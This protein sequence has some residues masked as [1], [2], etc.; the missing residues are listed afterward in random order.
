MKKLDKLNIFACAALTA[1][2]CMSNA[3]FAEG[4]IE[5]VFPDETAAPLTAGEPARNDTAPPV[6][7][8]AVSPPYDPNTDSLPEPNVSAQG[9]GLFEGLPKGRG[10]V[11]NLCEYWETNGYPDYVSYAAEFG[12]A[13][14]D[15]ATQ[16][17]TV[18]RS[19]TIGAVNITEEQKQEIL[20]LVSSDYSVS[21]EAARY[22][23]AYRKERADK[24]TQSYPNVIAELSEASESIY[25]YNN[26]YSEQEWADI[27]KAYEDGTVVNGGDYGLDT[28]IGVPEIGIAE[29]GEE[30]A[31]VTAAPT[32]GID[33]VGIDAA[34]NNGGTPAEN[35]FDGASGGDIAIASVED[36]LKQAPAA[37]IGGDVDAA[38][39]VNGEGAPALNEGDADGASGGNQEMAMLPA[40]Q[41]KASPIYMWIFICAAGIITAAT[42]AFVILHRAKKNAAVTTAGSIAALS[43]NP[44]KAEIIKAVK[45]S[46]IR[47]DDG[48]FQKIMDKI[49][50]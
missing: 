31:P 39:P 10:N 36:N 28:D 45:D 40:A 21:F 26:G 49:D 35:G 23:H 50:S 20:S 38:P 33:A 7:D 34:G 19:W 6:N 27:V 30:I 16:T 47:P 22:S 2:L 13:S 43:P 32:V 46:E 37:P 24:I 5:E 12:V 9:G 15:A 11:E 44:T 18:Y 25:I 14:Y 48:S 17:E 4:D 8:I 41:K 42:A 29:W 1:A 3:A